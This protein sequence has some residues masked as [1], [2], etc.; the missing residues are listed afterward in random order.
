MNP[1][2]GDELV[3]DVADDDLSVWVPED[4][5]INRDIGQDRSW[6]LPTGGQ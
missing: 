2:L 3:P 4:V 1:F 6:P 5:L